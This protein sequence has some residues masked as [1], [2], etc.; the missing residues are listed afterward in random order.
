[1]R[2]TTLKQS[3]DKI[4]N[5]SRELLDDHVVEFLDIVEHPLIITGH[6]IDSNTLPSKT[7]TTSYPVQV[8]L[9]LSWQIIVDHQGNLLHI[10]TTGQKISSNQHTGGTRAKF[11]HDDVPSIL[12][13]I[14]VGR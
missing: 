11:T 14:S 7:S 5:I 10:N 13:H 1:M 4:R 12:V 9:R 2:Q 8:I 6:K 3:L